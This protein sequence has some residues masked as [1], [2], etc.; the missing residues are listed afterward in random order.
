MKTGLVFKV[1]CVLLSMGIASGVQAKDIYVSA[2]GNDTNDGSTTALAVKT[3]SKA[4]TIAV[5]DDV[6]HI[7][8]FISMLDEPAGPGRPGENGGA[9]TGT[10]GVTYNTWNAESGTSGVQI[11]K[12]SLTFVGDEAVESGFDGEDESRL[13]M[14]RELKEKNLVFRHLT[15][16]NGTNDLAAWDNNQGAGVY[17]RATYAVFEYC[18]FINNVAAG[19]GSKEGGAVYAQNNSDDVNLGTERCLRFS[20]CEFTDNVCQNGG[21]IFFGY[22]NM[23][24]ENCLFE[25]NGNFNNAISPLPNARGGAIMVKRNGGDNFPISLKVVN[26]QFIGNKLSG[27]SGT[28]GAFH[29]RDELEN[30]TPRTSSLW[31]ERCAFIENEAYGTTGTHQGGAIFFNHEKATS[32]N[33]MTFTMVNSTMYGNRAK[34]GG[35]A[36]FIH[37]AGSNSTMNIVN[38]TIT[39]NEGGDNAGFGHGI[40]F[41]QNNDAGMEKVSTKDMKKYIYNTLMENNRS[42]SDA[43]PSDLTVN[44]TPGVDLTIENSFIGKVFT[45]G[46][47]TT[48][49]PSSYTTSNLNYDKTNVAGEEGFVFVP[50]LEEPA[51]MYIYEFY[52]IPLDFGAFSGNASEGIGFG[53]AKYLQNLNISNDQLGAIRLFTD[54]KCNIGAVEVDDENMDNPPMSITPTLVDQDLNAYVSGGLLVIESKKMENTRINIQIFDISGKLVQANS[55][56]ISLGKQY[57]P[58]SSTNKGIYIVKLSDGKNAYATKIVI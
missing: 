25:N 38:C 30:I 46:T 39:E 47:E 53:D 57:I 52:C 43:T 7:S 44:Y 34:Q 9:F 5:D 41:S 21:A 8:G 54:G 37:R 45:V 32:N 50:N 35:G 55:A 49:N 11:L 18:K 48:F 27:E 4:I 19:A 10:N 40:Y 29:Y 51:S 31:F 1:G 33:P 2:S 22:N 56:N 24:I 36:M 17:L 58:L 12:K 42:L 20:N 13:F 23:L 3:V 14:I 15:F 26:T 16:K 6:I 28:G